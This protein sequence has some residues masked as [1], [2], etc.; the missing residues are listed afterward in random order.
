MPTAGCARLTRARN[1]LAPEEGLHVGIGATSIIGA[2]DNGRIRYTGP[3]TVKC[4]ALARSWHGLLR[5]AGRP[6]TTV[7]QDDPAC[8]PC[9]E[10]Q[11]L[12]PA[13][14]KRRSSW[15]IRGGPTTY[16][17]ERGIRRLR[18]RHAPSIGIESG[19]LLT[20]MRPPGAP[21]I[22]LRM[23]RKRLRSTTWPRLAQE[24]AGLSA[25]AIGTDRGSRNRTRRR[26]RGSR[27]R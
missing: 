1:G 23:S 20:H 4:H 14:H 11:D 16:H 7:V 13:R 9:T 12:G 21:R 25:V 19:S 24:P 18:M 2:K 3:L 15:R 22:S 17:D 5:N 27:S 26:R 10:P 8:S 6:L